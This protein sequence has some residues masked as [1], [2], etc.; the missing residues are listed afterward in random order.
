MEASL[1]SEDVLASTRADPDSSTSSIVTTDELINED[2]IDSQG[3]FTNLLT[4]LLPHD[5]IITIRQEQVKM[6]H[7]LELSNWKLSSVNSVSESTFQQCAVDFR[8]T[9]KMLL[10]M[11][12]QLDSIFRRTRHLKAHVAA[13][14]P[15]AYAVAEAK[16]NKE[17]DI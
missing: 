14:Y 3:A 8:Q 1:G 12:K 2:T 5:K 17:Y 10:D 11:K 16:Y 6:L 15:E 4:E 13:N 9:N 7:M